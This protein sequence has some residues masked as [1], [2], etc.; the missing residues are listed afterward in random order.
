[1][2]TA[3]DD[4]AAFAAA[5]TPKLLRLAWVLTRNEHDAWDLVQ[6]SLARMG[7]KWAN[8]VNKDNP[9]AYA[10]R[11]MINL[12]L[13][14]LRRIRR[15]L[16]TP[17]PEA[18]IENKAHPSDS[19]EWLSAALNSLPGRQRAA[20]TLA[21]LEDQPISE[22]ARILD[23]SEGTVKTHLSRGR[24]A[25]RAAAPSNPARTTRPEVRG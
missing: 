22:I 16:L 8:I 11:T 1:M 19:I 15:E 5:E 13:N 10:R 17:S 20:V 3:D 2:A 23:C 24:Q 25:L 18:D 4:F 9:G 21:Y 6:D 7:S 12:N 14:R